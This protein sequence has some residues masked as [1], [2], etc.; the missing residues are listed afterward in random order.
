MHVLHE[1]ERAEDKK[2]ANISFKDRPKN[3]EFNRKSHVC[4]E[5]II[6]ESI[7]T[8]FEL[9]IIFRGSWGSR[10]NLCKTK[11]KPP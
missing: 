7:L 5:I 1:L 4:S 2:Q 9:T 3:P 10:E 11:T 8:T 6:F